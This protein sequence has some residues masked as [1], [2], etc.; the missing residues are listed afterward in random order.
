MNFRKALLLRHGEEYLSKMTAA[1]AAVAGLGGI[2]SNTAVLLCRMGIGRL[3]LVDYDLV[4]MTNINRQQ[5]LPG[6]IGMPKTEALADILLNINPEIQLQLDNVRV[7]EANISRIF[8]NDYLICEAFDQAESKAMLVNGILAEKDKTVIA[9][10]GMAGFG[11]SN[12]IVTK[13]ITDRFY[14][15]GDNRTDCSEEALSAARVTLCAA[16][17]ANLAV[18]IILG[19]EEDYGK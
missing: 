13:K 7:T 10:S 6:N 11:D 12:L 17:Q 15:C 9:C 4:D 1:S 2:G 19:M 18:R 3:H 5:Y 16:H 14:I 8:Q